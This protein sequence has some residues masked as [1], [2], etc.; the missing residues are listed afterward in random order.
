MFLTWQVDVGADHF[1]W[2]K[3]MLG[4]KDHQGNTALHLAVMEGF[5]E[6]VQLLLQAGV[7]INTPG[8]AKCSLNFIAPGIIVSNCNQHQYAESDAMRVFGPGAMPCGSV[9]SFAAVYE[10]TCSHMYALL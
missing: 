3:H 1:R 5:T 9:Y 6:S 8:R 2:Q 10:Y 7:D 4:L